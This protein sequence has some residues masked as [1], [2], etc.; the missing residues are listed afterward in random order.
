M[1]RFSVI[2]PAYNAQATIARCLD[3]VYALSVSETEF[4]V[5]VID[6]CSTDGTVGAVENYAR[7]H[8]NLSLLLQPQNHRQG[9][10]RNRGLSV[11]NGQ[12]IVFLD[13]DDEVDS[14]LLTALNLAS[15]NNLEMTAMRGVRRNREGKVLGW[16]ELG[17]PN[18]YVF[19]GTVLQQEHPYW[20]TGVVLYVYLKSFLETVDYPFEEDVLFEDSDFVNVHLYHATRMSY[21]DD[22]GYTIHENLSSTTHTTSYK[23]V[24]DYALLGTRMLDFYHRLERRDTPYADSILEGGSYNIMKS[25]RALFRLK[26][27]QDVRAFY[28]RLDEHVDRKNYLSYREPAY[29]WTPWTRFCLKHRNLT[30][31]LVGCVVSTRL[32]ELKRVIKK[33]KHA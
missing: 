11:A 17:Y 9:A 7:I 24:C 31:G 4:E 10:A 30:I 33:L 6:D 23:H 13:S 22:C 29:C 20:C 8:S 32:L 3:S 26:S 27:F 18:D 25:C 1:K 19:S 15:G 12:Y 21:S 14:G 5:I 28:D 2:I 16:F